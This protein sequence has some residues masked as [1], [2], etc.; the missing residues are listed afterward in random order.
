MV[1]SLGYYHLIKK[2]FGCLQSFL[3]MC[4]YVCNCL[5]TE[6]PRMYENG[7]RLGKCMSFNEIDLKMKIINRICVS[8]ISIRNALELSGMWRIQCL[9]RAGMLVLWL[10]INFQSGMRIQKG[11]LSFLIRYI[12][13]SGNQNKHY[14]CHFTKLQCSYLQSKP[15]CNFSF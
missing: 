4:F 7:V 1:D 5:Y 3:C 14:L 15:A 11:D 2:S 13:L 6:R 10:G 9:W 8:I 12:P